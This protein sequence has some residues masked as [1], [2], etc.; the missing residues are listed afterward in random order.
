MTENQI[1]E[2][3]LASG[4]KL[5]PQP[6]GGEDLN[7]YVYDFARKLVAE[8]EQER[9]QLSDLLKAAGIDAQEIKAENEQLRK[10]RDALTD[11][12]EDI[13]Q[14][15]QQESLHTRGWGE[16]VRTAVLALGG[17]YEHLARR[18][19]RM[20]AEALEEVSMLYPS[21]VGAE[22][23]SIRADLQGCAHNYRKQA[24]GES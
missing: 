15:A 13:T 5:K 9:D 14:A 24:E 6:D 7:P 4:F 1:K 23:D 21:G 19:A 10:E 17:S 22:F 2:V 3:A 16:Q 18:D 8:V 20:K 12:L 11:A